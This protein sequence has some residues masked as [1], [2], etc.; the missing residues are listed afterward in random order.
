M[1]LVEQLQGAGQ[2]IDPPGQAVEQSDFGAAVGAHPRQRIAELREVRAAQHVAARPFEI[3][4]GDLAGAFQQMADRRRAGKGIGSGVDVRRQVG[5][6]QC[7]VGDAPGHHHV[8]AGIDCLDQAGGAEIGMGAE[9]IAF[10]R[11]VPGDLVAQRQH[12]VAEHAG[13]DKAA[14]TEF[15]GERRDL[16]R[17]RG[18]IGGAEVRHNAALVRPRRRQ[19]RREAAPQPRIGA[20]LWVGAARAQARHQSA[21]GKTFEHDRV[22]LAGG[23]QRHRRFDAVAGKACATADGAYDFLP[24]HLQTPGAARR[25]SAGSAYKSLIYLALPRELEPL[26]SP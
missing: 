25:K 14:Q 4:A 8:G 16:M 22:H 17:G 5:G 21:L 3:A 6:K 7:G 11:R 23:R 19:Q 15:G 24:V 18:R 9:Q 13:Y 10:D 26:F 12:V 20:R 1:H 2:L